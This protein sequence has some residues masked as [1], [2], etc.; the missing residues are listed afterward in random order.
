MRGGASYTIARAQRNRRTQFLFI[1]AYI[2]QL[3][4]MWALSRDEAAA[5]TV[6]SKLSGS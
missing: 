2:I 1:Y 6:K 3:V 4:F 5:T